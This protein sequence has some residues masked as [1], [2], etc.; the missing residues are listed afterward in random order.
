MPDLGIWGVRDLVV[1]GLK[2]TR[3]KKFTTHN[4]QFPF[5]ASFLGVKAIFLLSWILSFS[6]LSFIRLSI[7]K[8]L[9]SEIFLFGRFRSSK[10]LGMSFLNILDIEGYQKRNGQSTL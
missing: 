7:S 8:D 5:V 9:F 10:L 6:T 3:M 1:W 2:G 4:N